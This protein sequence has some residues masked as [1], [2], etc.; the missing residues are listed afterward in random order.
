MPSSPN[1][2]FTGLA[3]HNFKAFRE[4]SLSLG[5]VNIL[6]GPNNCGKSTIISGLR[7][8][9]SGLRIAWSRAPQRIFFDGKS[10]IGYRIPNNSLPLSLENVHTNYSADPSSITFGLSNKNK[11]E[12]IF[13]SEGGCVLV[14][15]VLGYDLETAAQFRRQFPISLAVV[16]V[17]GPIEHN[18][19]LRERS[20]VVDALSTHRAS[21]HFRNYWRY[22]PDGFVDFAELVKTTWAGMEIE[23]PEANGVVLSMFCREDRRTRELYWVGFGF[24]IWLQLLTHLSRSKDDTL[25]VVDEPETYLHP[26]VQRQLL[27]IIRDIGTDVLMA[28][29]SSEIMAD[30]DPSEIVLVD[31]HRRT[32]ERLKDVVGV[33]RALDAIG[34]GQNITLAALARNRRVLFIEGHDDFWLLRRFARRL[35]LQELSTGIIALPSKG[36]SSWRRITTLASGIGEA[37]G[38]QLTIAAVYDRDYYCNEEIV[39]ILQE[40]SK[41]L[42]FAR[43]H[44]RKEIENYLLLPDA[45]TRSVEAL[46]RERASRNSQA[47][48]DKPNVVAI[49]EKIT[50]RYR[51]DV[52]S[53]MMAKRWEYFRT[54]GKDLA[55]VNRET[56]AWFNEQWNA[57][58][59][60]LAIVPGK[61]VLRDLR[62]HVQE[63]Y[64]VS[65]TDARIVEAVRRDEIPDDLQ[66]LLRDIDKF[67]RTAVT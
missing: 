29:H 34:S 52:L 17:L 4:Y 6:V 1:V 23:P 25:V 40:L 64:S 53:Q 8:L 37:L 16:P 33:Q 32:G 12:L 27:G 26:E 48:S 10:E 35:G 2:R 31:K 66:E 56:M 41:H 39:G 30:A 43:V 55:D 51:D 9:D 28:T 45:I 57:L 21:R 62:T 61:E 47:V 14:P 18:E 11:L 58:E 22:F 59:T 50:G 24:Q 42:T 13:P 7:A 54:A 65:L 49:L 46:I 19:H 38:A 36:F 44:K 60:R 67:R 5:Q 63:N 15:D 20:T 3:F